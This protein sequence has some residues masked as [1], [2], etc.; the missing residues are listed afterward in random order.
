[1]KK[2][3]CMS[4][5]PYT[6]VLS[7]R[8]LQPCPE[9]KTPNAFPLRDRP[10]KDSEVVL[11]MFIACTMCRFESVTHLT[12]RALTNFRQLE[13]K[14]ESQASQQKAKHGQV[15]SS[16][17]RRRTKVVAMRRKAEDEF[18]RLMKELDDVD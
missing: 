5:M 15:S 4:L 9:C 16:V 14:L 17:Q 13:L 8:D 18:A 10:Y 7:R 12:T 2:T 6:I 3:S 11:E 1:M